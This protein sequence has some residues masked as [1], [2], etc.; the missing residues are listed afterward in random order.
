[1]IGTSLR[2]ALAVGLHLRNDDPSASRKQK[3]NLGRIWWSLQSIESQLCALIGRPCIISND[4]CTVPLPRSMPEEQSRNTVSPHLRDLV[5]IRSTSIASSQTCSLETASRD[6]LG[7]STR[8]SFLQSRTTISVIM[9]KALSKLYLPRTSIDSWERIQKQILL[10]T[11][12]MDQW[13]E[14]ALPEGLG[15]VD[16]IQE[17][18]V[19]RERLLL[20]F[21]YYSARLLISRPSLGRLEWRTKSQ[22][23]ASAAFNQ[24][25]AG[26]C[27]QAAQAITRLFPDQPDGMF[28]AQQSPWWCIVHYIMQAIAVFLLEMYFDGADTTENSKEISE[29]VD[30]LV[31]WLQ[32][33]GLSNSVAD[34]AY[35]VV[36][37][38]IKTSA[39][40]ART[41]VSDPPAEN[42]VE[43]SFNNITATTNIGTQSTLSIREEQPVQAA[44]DLQL[45]QYFVPDPALHIPPVNLLQP[46]VTLNTHLEAETWMEYSNLSPENN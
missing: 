19:S 44:V 41:D 31:R 34:H 40:Q 24:K 7:T 25:T 9:Q 33:M 36:L 37:D 16:S 45:D 27:V 39:L 18:D 30:K 3:E 20:S 28:I 38:I 22:S 13:V 15:P 4:E 42:Q 8:Y 17:P 10:L 5:G 29:S 1:M 23:D 26:A 35:K 43:P 6:E 12:E 11:A 46:T 32:F 2:F 21:H 14:A